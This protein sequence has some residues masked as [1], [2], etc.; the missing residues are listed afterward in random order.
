MK[1][2]KKEGQSVDASILIRKGNKIITGCRGWEGIGR[3][4]EGGGKK[5]VG[6]DQVWGEIG[7]KMRARK[8]KIN[9]WQLRVRNWW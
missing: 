9:V 8:M 4:R 6:P 5:G 7:K 2:N 1:L 3:D